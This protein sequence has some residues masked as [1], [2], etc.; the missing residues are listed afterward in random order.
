MQSRKKSWVMASALPCSDTSLAPAPHRFG[1]KET[2]GLQSVLATRQC[3]MLAEKGI[4]EGP[5]R[6]RLQRPASVVAQV[7]Y[8]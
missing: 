4:E 6:L 8:D 3:R 5:V 7:P 2:N 1:A